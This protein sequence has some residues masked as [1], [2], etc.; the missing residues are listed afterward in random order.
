ML[1]RLAITPPPSPTVASAV[2]TVAGEFATAV[3][4]GHTRRVAPRCVEVAP[5]TPTQVAAEEE[6]NNTPP[7]HRNNKSHRERTAIHG[8]DLA[9]KGVADDGVLNRARV[10]VAGVARE[11]VG[12]EVKRHAEDGDHNNHA[13]ERSNRGGLLVVCP[14]D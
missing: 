14:Q 2:V 4:V 13:A 7:T 3:V 5:E 6:T 1:G 9:P 10:A 12:G 8:H 11:V